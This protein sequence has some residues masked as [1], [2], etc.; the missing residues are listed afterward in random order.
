MTAKTGAVTGTTPAAR[1]VCGLI[2]IG[3]LVLFI[4]VAWLALQLAPLSQDFL[5]FGGLAVVL[6]S[7]LVSWVV[8]AAVGGVGLLRRERPVLFAMF[9]CLVNS[10]GVAWLLLD[11]N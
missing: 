8:G 7:A 9:G 3:C 6:L 4:P 11:L 1:P 5:G 10:L 2:S